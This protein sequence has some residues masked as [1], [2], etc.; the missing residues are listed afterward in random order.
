VNITTKRTVKLLELM[1][2]TH[3][4]VSFS[5]LRD[6]LF[7]VTPAG[8]SRLLKDLNALGW[9]EKNEE[10]LYEPGRFWKESAAGLTGQIP[11]AERVRPVVERLAERSGHSATYVEYISS[12]AAIIHLAKQEMED[13]MHY[14]DLNVPNN[15]IL[16]N[17]MGRLCLAWQ[18]DKEI[19]RVFSLAALERETGSGQEQERSW[20]D[21]SVKDDSIGLIRSY[22]DQDVLVNYEPEMRTRICTALVKEGVFLGVM[23][24]TVPGAPLN[25]REESFFQKCLKEAKKEIIL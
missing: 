16:Y 13:S 22:R 21:L 7:D 6:N 9:I 19:E 4:P 17:T 5:F 24:I 15:R 23:G 18:S 8:L 10:G 3:G 1:G 14:S 25:K 2:L 12:Q 11:F 20:Y